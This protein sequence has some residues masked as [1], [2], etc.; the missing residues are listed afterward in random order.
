MVFEILET[1][2]TSTGAYFLFHRSMSHHML[3]EIPTNLVHLPIH[4][5]QIQEARKTKPTKQAQQQSSQKSNNS[6]P[7]GNNNQS[8]TS[9]HSNSGNSLQINSNGSSKDSTL[10]SSKAVSSM[11]PPPPPPNSKSLNGCDKRKLFNC[12][13]CQIGIKMAEAKKEENCLFCGI[14]DSSTEIVYQDD[15]Y[16]A[17][18]DIKPATSHHYLVIPKN[19]IRSVVNLTPSDIGLV[20]KLVE[21]GEIVLNNNSASVSDAR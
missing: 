13:D 9:G 12:K 6:N 16:L 18:R 20:R 2:T 10:E 5:S 4:T 17:F 15:D 1:F 14:Q 11:M 3:Q 21:I 19:H 8:S 7:S